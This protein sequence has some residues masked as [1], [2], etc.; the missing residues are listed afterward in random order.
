MNKFLSQE[1]LEFFDQNSYLIVE[2]VIDQ[3]TLNEVWAE[4]D[5]RLNVAAEILIQQGNKEIVVM[6]RKAGEVV[7]FCQFMPSQILCC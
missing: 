6:P 1:Q 5:Q 2:N 4:Y 7:S 3:A